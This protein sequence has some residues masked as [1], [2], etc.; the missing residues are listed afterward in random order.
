MNDLFRPILLDGVSMLDLLEEEEIASGLRTIRSQLLNAVK[1]NR[2]AV[3]STRLNMSMLTTVMSK[4]ARHIAAEMEK[5][6][7]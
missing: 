6:C 2:S 5:L 4:Y 3:L 7:L 1:E